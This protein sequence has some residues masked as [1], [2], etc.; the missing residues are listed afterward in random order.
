MTSCYVE[1]NGDL[2]NRSEKSPTGF[3]VQ[4]QECGQGRAAVIIMKVLAPETI[5]SESS[6]PLLGKSTAPSAPSAPSA[7]I[8]SNLSLTAQN[9][10]LSSYSSPAVLEAPMPWPFPDSRQ[11]DR[12]NVKRVSSIDLPLALSTIAQDI[13]TLPPS[14]PSWYIQA[15]SL[16]TSLFGITLSLAKV[17]TVI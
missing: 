6:D 11:L 1:T 9:S 17:I 5:A 3:G 8:T 10:L 16:M 2:S 7:P 13:S 4:R 12:D 15:F 14:Y